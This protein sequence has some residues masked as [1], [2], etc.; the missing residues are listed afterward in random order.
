MTSPSVTPVTPLPV[1][2]LR[3]ITADE[4]HAMGAMGI[5]R[6]GE[7]VELINGQILPMSPVG[8]SHLVVTNKLEYLFARFCYAADEPLAR[9]SVQN[10]IRL[11]DLSE[12]E[13]DLTLLHPESELRGELPRP[14]DVLLVVEVSDTTLKGD[15]LVKRPRY[16]EADIAEMWIVSTEGRFV[17]VARDPH[18]G[19]YRSIERF[20]A[21]SQ[22]A[23][24][25]L[26]LPGMPPI[27]V[28][29]LFRGIVG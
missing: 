18:R 1:D 12:P 5:F 2:G 29:A 27:E 8:N 26:A 4:Y 3:P 10:P 6:Q 14:S 22:Q 21:Q 20:S 11:N 19:D 24:V 15:R 13:P 7:R 28:E 17:E 25:P 16:A 23:F 9:V